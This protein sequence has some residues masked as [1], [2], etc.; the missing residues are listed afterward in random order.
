MR[1][2]DFA[3]LRYLPPQY[4]VRTLVT[5]HSRPNVLVYKIGQGDA[6]VRRLGNTYS[7]NVAPIKNEIQ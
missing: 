6:G 2:Y 7:S 5:A 4:P 1:T 3:H